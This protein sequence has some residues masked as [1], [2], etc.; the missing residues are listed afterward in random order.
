MKRPRRRSRLGQ[1]LRRIAD[2]RGYRR[3]RMGWREAWH[4]AGRVLG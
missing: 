1:L 2:A 4:R 3:Q